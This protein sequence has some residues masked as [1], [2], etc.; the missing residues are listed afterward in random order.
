MVSCSLIVR[1]GYPNQCSNAMDHY[2]FRVI[3]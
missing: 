1:G 2:K 3:L